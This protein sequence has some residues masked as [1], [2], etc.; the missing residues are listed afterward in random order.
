VYKRGRQVPG[1]NLSRSLGDLLGNS[2]ADISAEPALREIQL[3]K[4]DEALVFCSDGIWELISE[5]E[6]Y[7]I[8]CNS[9]S[10]GEAVQRLTQDAWDRWKDD[11]GMVDDITAI[12]VFLNQH[13]TI[14]M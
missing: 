6:A 8:V 5:Q 9:T 11:G 13:L 3:E 2:D 14:S 7:D 10:N 12:I 4:T 1:L